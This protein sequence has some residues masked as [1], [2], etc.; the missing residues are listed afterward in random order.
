MFVYC[1]SQPLMNMYCSACNLGFKYGT[2]DGNYVFLVFKVD[3]YFNRD[4]YIISLWI[5]IWLYLLASVSSP[6]IFSTDK[7]N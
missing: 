5:C 7:E 6:C 1:K 2:Q 4:R 3:I